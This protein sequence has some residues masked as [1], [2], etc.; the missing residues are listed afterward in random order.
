MFRE[1][2]PARGTPCASDAPDVRRRT[3]LSQHLPVL[4]EAASWIKRED[5]EDAYECL[6]GISEDGFSRRNGKTEFAAVCDRLFKR[7][8]V[9]QTGRTPSFL[10]DLSLPRDDVTGNI[11]IVTCG[12]ISALNW[13]P[14]IRSDRRSH[15]R[16]VSSTINGARILRVPMWQ[17]FPRAPS[18]ERCLRQN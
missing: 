6:H 11:L 1:S 8:V 12:S 15:A 3:Q 7:V 14:G 16:N 18:G 9:R 4:S 17:N 10:D 13:P 5:A 2:P